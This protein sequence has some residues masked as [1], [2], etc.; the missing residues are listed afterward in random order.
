MD[1]A[2]GVRLPVPLAVYEQER[3]ISRG[4]LGLT[5][6]GFTGAYEDLAEPRPVTPWPA[7]AITEG[8]LWKPFHF[9]IT[10]FQQCIQM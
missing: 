9:H 5:T 6:S 8:S 2:S 3:C 4:D 7:H 10:D 1:G